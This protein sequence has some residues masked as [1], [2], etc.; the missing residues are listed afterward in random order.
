M[1]ELSKNFVDKMVNKFTND[2]VEYGYYSNLANKSGVYKIKNNITNLSYVGSSSN[3]QT[4]IIKHFSECRSNRH[5][6][7]RLQNDFNQYGFDSFIV[8]VLEETSNLL[9]QEIKWQ[10]TIGINKLYN[11][12]ITDR[13]ISEKLRDQRANAHKN[14]HK[15][16]EYSKK[17]STLLS[18][19]GVIMIDSQ[20]KVIDAFD[21]LNAIS[22][23]YPDFAINTIR[24]VCNGNKASYKGYYWRYV[25]S[26]GNIVK[27]KND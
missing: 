17:M 22:I 4:R 8:T 19:Y 20:N 1:N 9:E 13:Y 18:K 27:N 24:G 23:K 3:I 7:V 15:T 26:N 21:T 5:T 25:D 6:N 14:T 11:D 16:Q 10:L 12:K 2:S